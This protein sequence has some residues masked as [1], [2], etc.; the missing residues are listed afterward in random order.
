MQDRLHLMAIGAHA[1]DVEIAAGAAMLKHTRRGHAATIVHLTLGAKGHPT[2]S[3]EVYGRQK[4]DE[5][6][7][8]ALALGADVRILPYLDAELEATRQA[9]L[10]VAD[11]IRE[12]RPTHMI[13]HW[14]G[15]IHRDHVAAYQIIQEAVFFA[16]LATI[17]TEHP[18]HEVLGPYLTE[19]WEDSSG[20]TPNIFLDVSDVF[21]D[22]IRAVKQ[23]ELFAGGVSDFDYLSYY[24][25]LATLRGTAAG[26]D[27]AVTFSTT[28][29]LTVYLSNGFNERISLYTSSSPV[30]QPRRKQ[31]TVG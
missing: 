2:L 22:W 24:T 25:A 19:N 10:A 5:A 20:Y 26:Y 29:P 3:E 1:G 13:T 30:F 28:S 15:S 9:K 21:D 27:K 17:M 7:G 18:A 6:R 14:P 8:A 4:L 23:Y 12:I 16:P 31:G 11:L